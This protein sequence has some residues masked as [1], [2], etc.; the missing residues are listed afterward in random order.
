MVKLA[1]FDDTWTWGQR[2]FG[3]FWQKRPDLAEPEAA[4]RTIYESKWRPFFRQVNRKHW[5]RFKG[6]PFIYFYDAGT[7]EPRAQSSELL[8][9]LKGLFEADFGETPFLCVDSGYFD[10]P[11]LTAVADARF[12]WFTFGLA[13]KRSRSTMQ[14]HVID[15]AM[16]R[17]DSVG[18][19]RPGEL[20]VPG[21]LLVKGSELLEQVLHDSSDA[22]LLV[23]ATWNDLG[24]GTGINRNYDYWVGAGSRRNISC[25]K[26][27][28]RR[29][30]SHGESMSL[31]ETELR[32]YAPLGNAS[33]LTRNERGIVMNVGD[34]RFRVE[35]VRADVLKLAIS[36]A[37]RFDEQPTFAV[38][39]SA[40]EP[41]PFEIEDADSSVTLRTAA[42]RLV[43]TKRAFGLAA[44]R[45]DGSVIFEDE[46]DEQGQSRGFLQLNDCFAV[47]RSMGPHDPVYGLGQKTGQSNR[48]GRKLVLWNTD[49]L[50]PDV[51]RQQRVF[52]ADVK[53]HGKD[54]KFDPYY[55]SIP[56]F[57]HARLDAHGDAKVA[58]F[59]IDNGYKASFDFTQRDRY[60][61]LF[62]GGQYTEYVFAGP[63][64]PQI[65][66]A[67]TAL[68]GR[69]Q[70]PPLW[71]LGHHQCQWKD[72]DQDEFVAVGRE[73]RERQLPCDSLWLDIGY[74]DG[75][76]VYTWDKQRFRDVP[77][78]MKTAQQD[79][80]KVITIV[81]PGVKL[82]PGYS[83]FE[84]GRARGV[85]C[86]TEAGKLYVG[87]VWPG[88]TV[89]PDF[90]LEKARSFWADLTAKHLAQG[91]AGI[92]NDMNEPATGEVEPFSMR[93]ERDGANHSH[94]RFHNQYGLLMAMATVEGFRRFDGDTRPF[95][96]SRAGFAGIQR[97]AA[98]W[99]G[100]N[101]SDWEHLAMSLPMATGLSLS[102]QPF[103][104]ADIP[105]FAGTPNPEMA[106]R[107]FQYGTL[108]PFSRCHAILG[109]PDQ[110]PWSFG[111]AVEKL[112]RA[113]LDL[114]YKLLPY[115]YAKFWD[116]H[117]TGAPIQR[118]L[119]YDFQHDATA[120]DTD[121]QYLLGDAL[122]VAPVLKA[123]QTARS[124][125]L[126]AGTWYD[127]HSGQVHAGET[128]VTTSA[129]LERIPLFARGGSVIACHAQK[130]QSTAEHQAEKLELHW[131][132][133]R[134][135]GEYRSTLHEDDGK[136]KAHEKGAFLRTT[137]TSLRRGG[138]LCLRATVTG[139]G[140][141]EH[142][143]RRLSL[144]LHG[145]IQ[146]IEL[147][148]HQLQASRGVVEFDNRGEAF[149][150][151]AK[152][153][154]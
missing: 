106:V 62:C 113:S 98:Q 92:W 142:R 66:E 95:V 45:A 140:Y 127:W 35:V 151:V 116:A 125:Y 27:V 73:Y 153:G 133:P 28:S 61:Y 80:F 68:T 5:Y 55:T 81:D 88:R 25:A 126:P 145:S 6:K 147:N 94:E 51:L 97:Y 130:L 44:Y 56:F 52:E 58:G 108:T 24:E 137:F 54:P 15:H 74:M 138:E 105:G 103:I 41:V 70:P 34:E 26:P 53:L 13:E 93:F 59:F 115:L 76:R 84:D 65:L 32:H 69:M 8:G 11:R 75:Y 40:G 47:S 1:L 100:D 139:Q 14:G 141:P 83:V 49:I 16:V 31:A 122:L 23:L 146:E 91:I 129:P 99:L 17:W 143:R 131:F 96:L 60:R 43:V 19:D 144:V 152:L 82:D 71:S 63:E 64:V 102:G 9:R 150:I 39:V 12:D 128:Y 90:S 36:Q 48:R 50:A 124:V 111:N 110:Y 30:R 104:G 89:F 134:A 136:T 37:G 107:W 148:G 78:M 85:F 7:L 57:Y 112:V 38:A 123:G 21:D 29:A 135:N 86:K 118:P 77:K 149:E 121:D 20:P 3:S 22:E 46:K 132:A 87:Q 154:N 120:R 4:A 117:E 79:G 42:L 10:D 33:A 109:E 114:R 101:F 72:Y 18:R 119:L 2:W 67:Y